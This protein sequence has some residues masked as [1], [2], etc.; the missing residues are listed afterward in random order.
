MKFVVFGYSLVELNK[1]FKFTDYYKR[2]GYKKM[3]PN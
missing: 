1:K 2:I 3:Y